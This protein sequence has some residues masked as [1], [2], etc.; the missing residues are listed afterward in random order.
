M[1]NKGIIGIIVATFVILIAGVLITSKNPKVNEEPQ[2]LGEVEG[3]EVSPESY[4]LGNIPYGGGKVVKDFKLKN[5]TK[6]ALKVKKIATSCMCTVAKIK[7]GNDESKYFGM[8]MTGDKNPPV[9]YEIAPGEEA[10]VTFE[11]DP[12]A[13]GP[14]GIGPI[15]RIVYI[16][17]ADPGGVKE[18]KFKGVVVK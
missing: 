15:D 8:E 6:A 14:S 10:T 7:V 16:T 1:E 4:D 17:F 5:T 12:A 2:V 11:F 13:H 18:L 3:I 9:S